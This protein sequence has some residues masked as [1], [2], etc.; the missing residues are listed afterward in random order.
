[1]PELDSRQIQP[2]KTDSLEPQEVILERRKQAILNLIEEM[3]KG[4]P[5]M[6]GLMLTQYRSMV[7]QFVDSLTFEQTE[8]LIDKVQHNI[9]DLRG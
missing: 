9:D 5:P 4:L 7:C 3:T 8:E 1:M 6:V 2:L